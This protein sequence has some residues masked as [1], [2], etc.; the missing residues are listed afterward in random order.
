MAN[1]NKQTLKLK[2]NHTWTAKP[3]CRIFVA[4]QGAVRFDIPQDWV[5]IPDSDSIKFHDRQPPDDDCTLAFSY[6]RLPP[7]DWSGLPLSQLVQQIVDGDTREITFQGK[8]HTAE[9]PDLE[10]AWTEVVFI[11]PVEHRQARSRIC[12]GR[13]SN[14]QPLITFDFWE[15]DAA[16]C[17]QVWDDVLRSLE[18]GMK[19]EDP[20]R[21]HTLH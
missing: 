8:M 4:D 2:K 14:I 1:W 9:R 10:I 21:G 12:L 5:V 16:R 11:D 15:E 13:G 20:T 18:L 6:M 19:I 3:G 17:G 7:I